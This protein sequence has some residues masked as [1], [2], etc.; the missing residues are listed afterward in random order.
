MQNAPAPRFSRT[1]AVTPQPGRKPGIDTESVLLEAG[2]T[3]EQIATMR[4]NSAIG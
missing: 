4:A 3:P 2:F 1:A